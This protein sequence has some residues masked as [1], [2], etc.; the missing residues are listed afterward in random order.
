ME[1]RLLF[2]IITLLKKTTSCMFQGM[3]EKTPVLKVLEDSQ[4]NFCSRVES[5]FEQF[6]LSNVQPVTIL[7]AYST[8]NVFC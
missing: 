6:K 5:L 1:A 8:A 7:K 2:R 3:F 4:E